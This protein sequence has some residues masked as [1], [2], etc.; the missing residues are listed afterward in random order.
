M[1]ISKLAEQTGVSTD[2]LRY[3]ERE[4]LI[5]SSRRP[6]GY[7]EYSDEMLFVMNYIQTAQRLGF[8]LAEIAEEIPSLLEAGLTEEKIKKVLSEK[9]L[10]VDK[11]IEDLQQVRSELKQLL[12][13]TCPLLPPK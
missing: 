11:K 1:L 12:E 8:T 10:V 9:I 6:N 4:G 5:R 2:T 3:Y 13:T 7:R